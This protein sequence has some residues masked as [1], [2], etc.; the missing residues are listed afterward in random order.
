MSWCTRGR[1]AFN[2]SSD[3]CLHIAYARSFTKGAC[4]GRGTILGVLCWGKECCCRERGWPR[5]GGVRHR[6]LSHDLLPWPCTLFRLMSWQLAYR[7]HSVVVLFTLYVLHP[8]PKMYI[9]VQPTCPAWLKNRKHIWQ[10]QKASRISKPACP[11]NAKI[12]C[13]HRSAVES[14]INP[15]VVP[16][17]QA[18]R[19]ARSQPSRSAEQTAANVASCRYVVYTATYSTSIILP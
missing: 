11:K 4:C 10:Q 16:L 17:L 15:G 12:M 13:G 7:V 14:G 6:Y 18:S 2:G 19:A 1:L 5:W 9:H 3:L 8:H